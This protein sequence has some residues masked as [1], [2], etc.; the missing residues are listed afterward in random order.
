MKIAKSRAWT[1]AEA[2]EA[3]AAL[4]AEPGLW[5]E[6][7]RIEATTGEFRGT[8]AGLRQSQI[9]ARLHRE[10]ELNEITDLLIAVRKSRRIELG[11]MIELRPRRGKEV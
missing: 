2:E 3:I 11:P 7:K 10:C 5:E 4:K 6:L 8:K 9:L 1:Q